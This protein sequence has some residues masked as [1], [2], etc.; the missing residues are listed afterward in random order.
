M[1]KNY[2]DFNKLSKEYAQARTGYPDEVLSY[3]KSFLKNR[4]NRILDLGCGTGISSR[5]LATPS[6]S[7]IGCDKAFAVVAEAQ[8][9][10]HENIHYIVG[11][12]EHLPFPKQL[13][14]AV[15]CFSSFHWFR[16]KTVGAGIK[17]ILKNEGYI[18][19]INKFEEKDFLYDFEK[20]IEQK[21]GVVLPNPHKDYH[22]LDFVQSSGFHDVQKII[23]QAQECYS[24]EKSFV[25]LQSRSYWNLVPKE[26][27]M[28]VLAACKKTFEE[29]YPTK[30]V[31]LRDLKII[32][33]SGRA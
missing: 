14:D 32:V 28:E 30:Q 17:R 29:K 12:A 24:L 7:I 25:Y 15:T 13:F 5:Q 33:V 21:I 22:P 2:A 27:Q 8:K 1:K 9:Q 31:L 10:L 3:C 6:T 16:K 23:F 20:I 11:E 19:I 18:F 4:K 26:K